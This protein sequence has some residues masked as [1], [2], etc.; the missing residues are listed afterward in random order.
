MELL[1]IVTSIDLECLTKW[2]LKFG[3]FKRE[4]F[5]NL[6]ANARGTSKN[7]NIVWLWHFHFLLTKKFYS[8]YEKS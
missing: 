4:V 3:Y 5:E 8:S 6:E 2:M 1:I 7:P